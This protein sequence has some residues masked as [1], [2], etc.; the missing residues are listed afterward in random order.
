MNNLNFYN[1]NNHDLQVVDSG[2]SL[3]LGFSPR[4]PDGGSVAKATGFFDSFVHGL[5]AVAIHLGKAG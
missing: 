3:N 2:F 4:F 5:K 1:L